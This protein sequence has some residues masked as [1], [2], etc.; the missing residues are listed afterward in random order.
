MIR[1]R[2]TLALGLLV[3]ASLVPAASYAAEATF[4][5][6]G[7]VGLVP[8]AGLAPATDF[9]G[10]TSSDEKVKVGLAELPEAAFSSVD[11]AVKENKTPPPGAAKP[12]PLEAGARQAYFLSEAGKDGDT[13]V[14]A[15]SLLVPGEKFTGYV[16]VQVRGDAGSAFSED[17]IKKMLSTTV[18]RAEVPVD[19]QLAQL[20]FKVSDLAGFKT[21]RTIAPRSAILLTDGSDDSTLDSAPYMMVGLMQG[22]PAQPDDRGRFARDVAASIP[23]LRETKMTTNEPIRIDGTPGYETRIEGVTG[24]DNKP[25]AVVQWLRFG[26]GQ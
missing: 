12:Q 25:V 23:G 18:T 5:P 10:F 7:R 13:P 20:A 24:K 9:I 3:L 17:A 15:Y 19:E 8:I 4:P 21:V 14:Q 26:N 16:I 2:T 22:A 1:T 6:G 11:S